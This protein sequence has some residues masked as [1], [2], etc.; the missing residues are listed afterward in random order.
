MFT[1]TCPESARPVTESVPGDRNVFRYDAYKRLD[2]GVT[3]EIVFGGTTRLDVTAELL[4]VFDMVN[5]VAS[6]WVFS[7]GK[8]TRVP[9]RLTPRTFNLRA[10]V[11]F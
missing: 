4:N 6:H 9:V 8:W 2:A 10:R 7:G 11:R 1:Q 3:R 5:E